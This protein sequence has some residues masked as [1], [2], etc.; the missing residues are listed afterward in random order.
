MMIR[1]EAAERKHIPQIIS[2]WH[3]LM[4]YHAT[5]DPLFETRQEG[6]N[7]W[8][9]Y[10]RDLMRMREG[11]VF[12]ALKD[13]EVIGYSV[14]KVSA[15]PPLFKQEYYGLIMDM[16]VKQGYQRQGT[17]TM[18]LESIY[19]WAHKMGLNRIELQVVPQNSQG[20]AFWKK[21]SFT[22]YLHSL[23]KMI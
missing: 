8:E 1:V 19:D 6:A 9:R 15:H 13:D 2:L 11:K 12:I 17:G 21:H 10:I 23:Y 22:D 5:L 4:E 20:Y 18:L 14:C 16:A 7:N 3:E